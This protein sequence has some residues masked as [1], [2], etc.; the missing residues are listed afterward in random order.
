MYRVLFLLFFIWTLCAE[1]LPSHAYFGGEIYYRDFHE[2]LPTPLQSDEKGVMY[3]W[4]LGYDFVKRDQI[5]F[6]SL[7]ER[8]FGDSRYDGT[9]QNIRTGAIL[10]HSSSTDNSFFTVE[11]RAGFT[12]PY[13][14]VLIT[15]FLGYGY[16]SW[17]R[18][19]K[20]PIKG[21]DEFYQ[22]QYGLLGI[23]VF[24]PFKAWDVGLNFGAAKTIDPT[25]EIRNFLPCVIILKLASA[26]QWV[27]EIP[28]SYHISRWDFRI[29]SFILRES[30]GQSEAL[31]TDFLRFTIKEPPG[32][33]Y[34]VGLSAQTG[35]IF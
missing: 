33:A 19:M 9:T 25:L 22:W 3:G 12:L 23:R 26:W 14:K 31:D 6:G 10:P 5:Y 35:L 24:W 13:S 15:P 11:G 4:R 34:S 18:S 16:H 7:L 28:V 30:I 27:L 17:L 2:E 29:V 20:D 8:S 1:R 32:R 21:Y